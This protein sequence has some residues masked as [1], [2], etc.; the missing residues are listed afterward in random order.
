MP[1][2]KEQDY[3]ERRQQIINGALQVF[4]TMGFEKATNK[5]IARAAGIGSPGLI[6]H[7]FQD[8]SDLFRQAIEQHAPAF[9]LLARPETLMA[10]PPRE[11][12]TLFASKFLAVF[13]NRTAVAVLKVMVGEV[14]RRPAVAD[15]VNQIGPGRV[16]PLLSR[17]FAHQMEAGVLR[18]MDPN[19]ATRCFIGAIIA[20]VITREIFPQPDS[21]TLSPDMMVAA[22]VDVF[23]HGMLVEPDGDTAG[24]S[25]MRRET[26]S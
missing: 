8:K 24:S 1:R 10:L 21:A 25:D 18:P 9:Q 5:D 12:L 4:A 7:Y 23:L 20:Y 19:A 26:V 17:Y 13:E 2:R 22:A 11:A 14:T 6:Y 16:I 3:E 15:M